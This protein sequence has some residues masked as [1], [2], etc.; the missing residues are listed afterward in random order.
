[1]VSLAAELAR[2]KVRKSGRVQEGAP[3]DLIQM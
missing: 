3:E 1:M 2:L